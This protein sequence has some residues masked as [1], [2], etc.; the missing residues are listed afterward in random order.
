MGQLPE[1]DTTFVSEGGLILAHERGLESQSDGQRSLKSLA[2]FNP[3]FSQLLDTVSE[4]VT[5][6]AQ[7]SLIYTLKNK[8]S[9]LASIVQWRTFKIHGTFLF[10][11]RFFR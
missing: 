2:T 8:G 11:K 6:T 5:L 10:H 7:N 9:L 4:N 3:I 1:E